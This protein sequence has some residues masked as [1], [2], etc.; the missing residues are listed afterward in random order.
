MQKRNTLRLLEG[1]EKK[2]DAANRTKDTIEKMR[3]VLQLLLTNTLIHV[4]R[5][6]SKYEQ[7]QG[8]KSGWSTNFVTKK[9]IIHGAIGNSVVDY[10]SVSAHSSVMCDTGFLG[11]IVTTVDRV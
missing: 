3:L 1:F 9:D 4:L 10:F 8:K 5:K 11:N 6:S 2:G 7:V